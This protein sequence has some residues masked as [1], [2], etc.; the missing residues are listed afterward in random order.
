MQVQLNQGRKTVH[1]GSLFLSQ[2]SVTM[3][4]MTSQD[5]NLLGSLGFLRVALITLALINCLFPLIA[6]VFPFLLEGDKHSFG[7]VLI[8][9]VAPVNAPL[10]MVV[11][12]FD[13]I[14]SRVRAA[15]SEGSERQ[16]FT[17]IGRIEL[18]VLGITLL[19]WIPYFSLK[20][21]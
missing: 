9:I 1:H 17:K 6:I 14:M 16:R 2:V 10:L 5:D 18:A 12:L 20:L 7:S 3:A 21:S 11:T 15:D 19:V 13:Y 8:T 4:P